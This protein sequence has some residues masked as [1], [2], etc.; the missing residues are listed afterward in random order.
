M[1][2]GW[3]YCVYLVLRRVEPVV[4]W[5][6][7]GVSGDHWVFGTAKVFDKCRYLGGIHEP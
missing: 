3:M 6:L 5:I 7:N 2:V 4:I 1:F